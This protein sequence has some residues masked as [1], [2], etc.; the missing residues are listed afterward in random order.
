MALDISIDFLLIGIAQI[1]FDAQNNFALF[2]IELHNLHWNFV[3]L[4]KMRLGCFQLRDAKLRC[5][6]ESFT[7]PF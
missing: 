3:T 1:L 7:V 5:R 4:I 6:D 2:L